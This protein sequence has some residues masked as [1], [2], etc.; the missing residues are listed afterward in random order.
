M[1]FR[2]FGNGAFGSALGV[3]FK[4]NMLLEDSLG[5]T[6]EPIIPGDIAIPAVPSDVVHHVIEKI[7]PFGTPDSIMLVSKGISTNKLVTQELIEKGVNL[8]LLYFLG[9]NL[10]K[11]IM[12]NTDFLS[13][14]LAGPKELTAPIAQFLDDIII[15]QTEDM[16]LSQ[17]A[18]IIKNITAFVI[19][20]IQPTQNARATLITQG[21]KEAVLLA[22]KLG[23]DI[24]KEKNLLAKGCFSDFILTCTSA[25][26]RNVQAGMHMKNGT[27]KNE[28]QESLKSVDSIFA[29]KEDLHLPIVN[30]FYN[31]VKN[32]TY[33]EKQLQSA[34]K[35]FGC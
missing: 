27:M 31:L 30:F 8:P 35:E 7:L 26:S 22:Q 3:V 18:G 20:F 16:I 17:V 13:A 19:G 14:T 29:L 34:I 32:N 21:M 5:D 4:K 25:N 33:D 24:S 11:E 6:F 2:I 10:A 28:T 15:D 1:R 12:E 9:P 23:S